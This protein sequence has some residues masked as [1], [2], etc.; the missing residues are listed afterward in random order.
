[1]RKS[2][3]RA[4]AALLLAAALTGCSTYV[5]V[6]SDPEGAVITSATGEENFGRAPVRIPYR[7]SALEESGGMIPGFV[8]TWPS[9][10]TAA[11]A[12]P[13]RV[14]SLRADTRIELKRPA[15]APDLEQDLRFALERAQRRADAAER[16]R[17]HLLMHHYD[18]WP[19]GPPLMP[20]PGV[21]WR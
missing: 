15:D 9:G 1:M 14:E 21:M 7:T 19:W 13:F 16:E 8:A 2:I 6:S 18:L 3:L 4:A 10:A 12:S 20:L 5:V 11:T 17:D